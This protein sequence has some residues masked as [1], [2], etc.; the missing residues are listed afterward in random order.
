SKK[1]TPV[2][3]SEYSIP[4]RTSFSLISVSFVFLSTD[5]SLAILLFSPLFFIFKTYRHRICV[6]GKLLRFRELFDVF[7]DLTQGLPGI[8][9]NAGFLDKVV[10]G[11][12]RKELRRTVGG[13]HMVRPGKI[14]SQ[15][16]GT[17]FPNKDRSGVSYLH[18]DL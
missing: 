17:V 5:A 13:K 12:R 4:S 2:S 6:R 7:M 15:R 1:P 11:K 18:H 16:L 10:H 3:I 14:I 9:N 8:I